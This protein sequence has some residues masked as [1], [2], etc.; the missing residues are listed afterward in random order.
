MV[1][2]PDLARDGDAAPGAFPEKITKL[3]P[4]VK[5]PEVRAVA[6]GSGSRP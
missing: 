5:R 2:L 3:F 6:A 1:S 4:E